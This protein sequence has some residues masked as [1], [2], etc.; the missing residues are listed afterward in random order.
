LKRST[1]I[2]S[3]EAGAELRRFRSMAVAQAALHVAPVENAGQ[4]IDDRLVEEPA[5]Q[6][7]DDAQR[8][9]ARRW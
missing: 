9:S 4:R 2:S 8:D 6:G 3:S 1:S 5:M 7:A